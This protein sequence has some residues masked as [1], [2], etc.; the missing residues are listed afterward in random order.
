MPLKRIEVLELYEQG[1]GRRYN[2]LFAVNTAI[3][4]IASLKP[5]T[6]SSVHILSYPASSVLALAMIVF[7]VTMGFDIC[8][9]GE[10]MRK[11]S[12][13][14]ADAELKDDELEAEGIDKNKGEVFLWKGKVVLVLLCLLMVLGWAVVAWW[15]P[16]SSPQPA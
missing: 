5:E 13:A 14:A 15:G 8:A 12:I 6:M 16:I 4:A 1:K 11:R 2:L 3:F 10:Q 9:F 7:T